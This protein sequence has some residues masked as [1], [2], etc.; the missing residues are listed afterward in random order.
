V[1]C[2]EDQQ[3]KIII[4]LI[5]RQVTIVPGSRK[6]FFAYTGKRKGY[7]NEAYVNKAIHWKYQ[8]TMPI[9]QPT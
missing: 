8:L 4:R 1:A 3:N 6:E 5:K 2:Q 9:D 7:C